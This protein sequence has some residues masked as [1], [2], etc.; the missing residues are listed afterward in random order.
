MHD[1]L[2]YEWHESDE[3]DPCEG[4]KREDQESEKKIDKL[5]FIYHHFTLTVSHDVQEALAGSPLAGSNSLGPRALKT[6]NQVQ[7][8]HKYLIDDLKKSNICVEEHPSVSLH[9]SRS[10]RRKVEEENIS[11]N[12]IGADNY[13]TSSIVSHDVQETLA[14]SPLAGSNSLGPRALKTANQVQGQRKYLIDVLKK[15][16]ICVEEHPSV[17]KPSVYATVEGV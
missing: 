8:Q 7:G 4:N 6:A 2:E 16:N 17:Y 11:S 3:S 13:L 5:V 1:W 10:C 9:Y 12:L 14:G 15:S